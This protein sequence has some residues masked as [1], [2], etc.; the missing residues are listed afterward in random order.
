MTNWKENKAV[1]V[2]AAAVFILAMIFTLKGL[3]GARP[4]QSKLTEAEKKGITPAEEM[5]RKK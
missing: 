2:A 5:M 3:I 1:G 4:A